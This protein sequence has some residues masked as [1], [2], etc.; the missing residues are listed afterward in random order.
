MKALISVPKGILFNTFFT[1]EN[2]KLAESLGEIIWN[3]GEEQMS[4]EALAAKI[5]GCDVYVALWGAPGLTESVLKNAP[6]LKLLTVLGST[7]T[8]FVSEAMWDRGIRVISGFDYF[9]ESTAEG[10]IAYILA[11]LR[12]IPFYQTQRSIRPR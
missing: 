9:S 11:A 7:V 4:E 12:K 3:D 10:A 5:K 1:E 6:D 2:I 8:P